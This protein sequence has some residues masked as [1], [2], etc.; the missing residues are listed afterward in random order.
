MIKTVLIALYVI[1]T[2]LLF[3]PLGVISLVLG[4]LGFARIMSRIVYRIGQAWALLLIKMAGVEASVSG[5]ENIP[6]AGG[7]C[8][9]SNHVG[10]FDIVLLFAYCGRPIGFIAKKELAWVPFF[11]LCVLI[12]GGLFIDRKSVRKAIGT[13]NRGV[14]KIKN[15]G[16][17]IIFPEGHRSRGGGLLPFHPGSLKLATQAQAPIVPVAIAGSY[18]VFEKTYRVVNAPVKISFCKA[19][20][21]AGLP[22]EERKHVLCDRIFGAIK[23]ELES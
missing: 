13:I 6:P 7:L 19:V 16:A 20:P 1:T 21:T 3:F 11:N 9:V 15:G 4:F 10:I 2:V 12:I 14:A 8:F 17:M 22:N 5:R 18:D 23:E